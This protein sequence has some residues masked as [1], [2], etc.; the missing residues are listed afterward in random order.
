MN[1]QILRV[2][3]V[4][5]L[6]V[7]KSLTIFDIEDFDNINLDI[8]EDVRSLILDLSNTTEIDS[9]GL[10]VVLRIVSLAKSRN[11]RVS[12][13]ASDN[14]VLFIIKI[15]RLD[16]IIPIYTSLDEALNS[17]KG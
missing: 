10:S 15:D 13:V 6:K 2:E 16:K 8:P 7:G 3:D 1:I 5:I 14:K 12:I 11:I 4:A 17:M 9:V